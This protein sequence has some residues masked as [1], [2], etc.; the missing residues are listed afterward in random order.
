MTLALEDG[1]KCKC[2]EPEGDDDDERVDES[3]ED[4]QAFASSRYAKDTLVEEQSTGFGSS[5]DAGREADQ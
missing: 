2:E 3:V 5:E 1:Q 4:A